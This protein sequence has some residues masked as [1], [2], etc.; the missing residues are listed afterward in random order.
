V[1]SLIREE[2]IIGDDS[3]KWKDSESGNDSMREYDSVKYEESAKG[4]DSV[5]DNDVVKYEES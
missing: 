2:G 4:A 3:V 1:E 5:R